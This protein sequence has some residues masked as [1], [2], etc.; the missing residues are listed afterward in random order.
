MSKKTSTGSDDS[1]PLREH[2]LVRK[3][4][5]SGKPIDVI[6]IKGYVGKSDSND[7][8]RLYLNLNFNEYVEVNKNDIVHAEETDD[9]EQGGTCIWIN[10]KSEITRVKVESTKEQ[11]RFIEGQITTAQIKPTQ[12]AEF[13]LAQKRMS[14]GIAC[15]PSRFVAC[16]SELQCSVGFGCVPSKLVACPSETSMFCRL[17]MRSIQTCSMPIRASM[18]CRHSD[19]FHPNLLLAH[20]SLQCSVGIGCI[21][22]R[23]VACPSEL[24]C[25]VGFGCV[26][27]VLVQCESKQIVCQ[28]SAIDACPSMRGC[29]SQ[30]ACNDPVEPG[31]DPIMQL[32]SEMNK[33][34]AKVK[35]LEEE[36][37]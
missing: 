27:S 24:Q 5:Q 15:I 14:L 36:K 19:A 1:N 3:L 22:S 18:F 37:T 33:L 16:P 30:L 34:R 7:I 20:Q 32:K 26:P 31:D 28:P 21:P 6:R 25:S 17:R 11:A 10:S 8:I 23:F 4:S 9:I 13:T 35:K 29:P 2:E 12:V